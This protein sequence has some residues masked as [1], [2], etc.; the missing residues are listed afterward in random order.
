MVTTEET[1]MESTEVVEL[2]LSYRSRL[3]GNRRIG[4]QWQC[5]LEEEEPAHPDQTSEGRS[6]LIGCLVG[7]V[8]WMYTKD[9]DKVE[10]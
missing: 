4:S 10:E 1:T 6:E 7:E 8:I 5:M 9:P 3:P 2:I